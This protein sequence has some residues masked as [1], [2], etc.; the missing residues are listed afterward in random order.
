LIWEQNYAPIGGSLLWSSLIA[1]LPVAALLYAIGIRRV[2]AW[3]ASLFGLLAAAMVALVAYRM[4]PVLVINSALYGA[5][6][7][8]FPIF[9][10][11]YWA[12]VLYR[13]TV[14]TGKFE[15]LKNSIG[16]L[17]TDRNLQALLIAFA[18]GAFLE[19]AAGFGTPVA[20]A[21]AILGGLGFPAFYAA[22]ICLLANTAPVAFGSIGIPL[23]TLAATTGLPIERLSADVGRLCA[24]VSLIIPAY[25]VLV[26][27]GL[28]A[29]RRVWPAAVVCGVT[30]AGMQF[31]I[32]NYV[33]PYL[34]DILGSFTSI[35]ALLALLR[36]WR[37]TGTVRQKAQYR[38]G[39]IGF[40]LVPVFAA[41]RIY[42]AVESGRGESDPGSRNRDI[43]VAWIAQC[44]ATDSACSEHP[45][46]V[47][48][49]ISYA[50]PRRVRHSM[51]F[52]YLRCRCFAAR[53]PTPF[54]SI[55][56]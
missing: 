29:V 55:G 42:S 10:V 38:F 22:G 53:E 47:R 4:P 43:N 27:G 51:C 40:G 46:A 32:S 5:A 3:K 19:G 13:L 21:A 35:L 39:D 17:T 24:P 30:F 34:T 2:A 7:G 15:I 36:V 6:F 8:A 45:P 52:G 48:C 44:C 33:G 12:I 37:P 18:F 23:V 41:D 20:V 11:V 16:H 9:W 31:V 49:A 1:A 25:L 54:C 14:D 50:L 28:S 56:S 26:M